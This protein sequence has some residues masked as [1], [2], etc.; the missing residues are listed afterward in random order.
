MKIEDIDDAITQYHA[1][2]KAVLHAAK[3]HIPDTAASK[4]YANLQEFYVEGDKIVA[5]IGYSGPY[6]GSTDVELLPQ[7]IALAEELI[8]IESERPNVGHMID[9]IADK[10]T[11]FV[12][13][14]MTIEDTDALF[15]AI[16]GETPEKAVRHAR[17]AITTYGLK[18]HVESEPY[19]K[20]MAKMAE[21]LIGA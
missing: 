21:M 19:R 15:E 8:R 20:F 12:D 2:S 3:G 10:L 4:R 17:R 14:R 9:D 1:L 11:G 13:R 18:P 7:E 6:R 5:V 16:A